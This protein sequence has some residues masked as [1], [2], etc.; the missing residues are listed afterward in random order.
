[1]GR[2]VR[3]CRVRGRLAPWQAGFEGWLLGRGY[4]PSAVFHRCCLLAAL[5]LWL[6]R[7]GLDAWELT[8]ERALLFVAERRAAGLKTW[9]SERWVRLPLEYLREVGAIPPAAEVLDDGPV[10]RV[11][12]GYREYLVLERD[13]AESTIDRC[14]RAASLFLTQLPDELEIGGLT[15]A[16]VSAFLAR[17]CPRRTGSSAKSLMSKFRPFVRYLYVKGLVATPLV[18]AVPAVASQRDRSLP[19]GVQPAVVAGLLGSCD[20][21]RTVGRRAYAILLLLVRLGLR[22][23]EVA[24][25]TLQDVDWRRGEI[26]IHG[27]G[28]RH[29]LL[30][31]PVDVGEA[32]VSYLRRRPVDQC[33]AVFA[34]TQAPRG[35]LTREAVSGVV[36]RACVR[37]GVPV[38]GAHCGTPRRPGCSPAAPRLRRS[39]RSCATATSRQPPVTTTLIVL[40]TGPVVD[41]S[42]TTLGPAPRLT[43]NEPLAVAPSAEHFAVTAYLPGVPV[44]GIMAGAPSFLI[45]REPSLIVS[46][47]LIV[48]GGQP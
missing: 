6:E 10:A 23:G 15:A 41:G 38:I 2:R 24:A 22:A 36:R 31:L 33:P 35:P 34:T 26:V 32:V 13:L 47:I 40:V 29:D 14:Q 45:V 11:L 37:A 48:P 42:S 17:E 27:K 43:T 16:D 20:R 28:N 5:S 1:M 8:E 9:A 7:Q 4:L 39:R 3:G 19:R 30:P 44:D 21:R 46:V 25:I 12:A 18:W